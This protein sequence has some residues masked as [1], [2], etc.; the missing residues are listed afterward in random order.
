MDKKH[1][2]SILVIEDDGDDYALLMAACRGNGIACRSEWRR[3]GDAGKAYLEICLLGG[4]IPDL[5]ITDLDMPGIG[6]HELLEWI[7][8][9]PALRAIPVMVLTGSVADDD[10]RYCASADHYFVKPGSASGW[11]AIT[12]MIQ[13][14]AAWHGHSPATGGGPLDGTTA[15]PFL[16]HIEDNADDRL[17]FQFAFASSGLPGELLQV[18]SA[19]EALALLASHAQVGSLPSLVVLDLNLPGTN[20]RDFLVQMRQGEFLQR[21]P[22]IVLSGSDDFE[23]V[24]VCRDLYIIDYVIKPI[25][26][27]QMNE[28]V[29]TF[30][31]WILGSLSQPL[32]WKTYER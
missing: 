22:V 32:T 11:N 20:G 31:P 15:G 12:S 5:V 6:G 25:T 3:S 26:R 27:Q 23:D 21:V 7:R 30:R 10:R 18:G 14:H 13:R 16:L 24:Q 8:S 28:F 17:L 19:E 9:N 2:F 29:S 4:R 1:Q